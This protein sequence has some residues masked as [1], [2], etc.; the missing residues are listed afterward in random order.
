M[1]SCGSSTIRL[2]VSVFTGIA[3]VAVVVCVS[4]SPA[5]AA[6]AMWTE[7]GQRVTTRPGPNGSAVSVGDG[8]RGAIVAFV[9]DRGTSSDIQ[10]QRI[11]SRGQIRW[12][13]QG[14]AVRGTNPTRDPFARI[15]TDDCGGAIISWRDYRAGNWDV[16]AQRVGSDGRIRW[17][18][19]GVGV[20]TLSSHQ[21]YPRITADGDGGAIICWDDY[22]AGS[23]NRDIYVQRISPSGKLLWTSTGVPVCTASG[24]Q[25]YPR[26][27]TDA[28]GGAIVTW[29]DARSGNWDVYAQR[30]NRDG[31]RRWQAN[32]VAVCAAANSQWYPYM[33]AVGYGNT[34]IT[35]EDDRTGAR[36][37]YA[38]M[39][40]LDGKHLWTAHGNAVCNADGPQLN[41]AKGEGS[42]CADGKGGAIITWSDIRA[43][44]WD[45]YAQRM[46]P[47]G[48][49]RW[50]VNGAVVSKNLRAKWDSV[51]SPDGSGGGIFAWRWI[52]AHPLGITAQ[53]L[54]S[55]GS[56]RWGTS[57]VEVADVDNPAD[58]AICQSGRD[59][60]VVA[61]D[62]ER[63]GKPEVY[64]QKLSLVSLDSSWYL[65]EGTTAWGFETYLS[66]M[67][68]NSSPVSAQVTYMTD[69]GAVSG[70]K[71]YLSGQSQLTLFPRETLGDKDFSTSVTC[72]EGKAISVDRTM[73]WTGEGAPSPEGHSSIGATVP[74][75]S[76]YLPEGSSNWGFET[77]LLVQN[78]TAS[79]ATCEVTYMV[80][81]EGPT[82]FTRKVP[83][84]SRRTYNMAEDIGSKDASVMVYSDRPV[85]AE[86][87]MYRNNRRQGHESIG[88]VRA[89]PAYFLAEGTT[90]WGF[91]TYVLVQ[92]PQG[93]ETEVEITYMTDAGPVAHPE[94]PVKIPAG[95]RKTV[96]VN[97][98]LNNRDFSTK[99][100][101]NQPI[102][103]ERAM[104][105]NGGLGEACHDS[106]G[107]AAPHRFFNLPDG[108]CGGGYETWTLVQNPNPSDLTVEIT[109]L[110]AEGVDNKT[111][112]ETI[113]A[114]SRRTFN[115][116][117]RY[118]G[119]EVRAG[120]LV[121]S[122]SS[123]SGKKVIVERAMYWNSRGAGTDTV[124]GYS[125]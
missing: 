57:G 103:A 78:P 46:M 15:V 5:L 70:G 94:N 97:D 87:S 96:R 22:R 84:N 62:D 33:A 80:E 105:W 10:A 17:K 65:A 20:C 89:A 21:D 2:T 8:V 92:N 32:G 107:I 49:G 29:N 81:N 79:E 119:R 111:F 82:A 6:A 25:V 110:S 47:S 30:V 83:A 59:G 115:M 12:G 116:A 106:I 120:I 125:D 1:R 72:L 27:V 58:L 36:Q 37:I 42:I 9:N 60:A 16:Y 108:Q 51:V 43:G 24:D 50:P 28:W 74:D 34:I 23:S 76:W 55:T 4:A 86:R 31:Q 102:I 68:P 77:W 19:Q 39:L 45:V 35:W 100:T 117:D 41:G 66:I 40:D 85:I 38:Q 121:R 67:N 71:V 26:V 56:R 104:Y 7:N 98:F 112:T 88:T 95:S 118:P 124:G 53:A 13:S 122:T 91:T 44:Q 63:S 54:S 48:L 69:A 75:Y 3:L 93:S 99:V 90:A 11:D 64:A 101:G 61:W 109:Y 114:E 73:Y 52:S 123:A 113:P 18:T 14:T